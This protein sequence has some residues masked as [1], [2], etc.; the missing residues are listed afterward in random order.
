M[1]TGMKL[2]CKHANLHVSRKFYVSLHVFMQV[3]SK[4]AANLQQ[5]CIK[6]ASNLHATCKFA[7]N[8]HETCMK[9]AWGCWI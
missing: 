6:L 1:Q 7:A 5:T 2:G 3:C 8:L 4:L 9:L